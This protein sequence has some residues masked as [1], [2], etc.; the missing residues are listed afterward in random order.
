MGTYLED[1]RVHIQTWML[2][3]RK[4]LHI[5]PPSL[6]SLWTASSLQGM[7]SQKSLRCEEVSIGKGVNIPNYMYI[8]SSLEN[9]SVILSKSLSH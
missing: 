5:H 6:Q 3:W 4:L 2:I 7:R 8:P 1:Q 9:L